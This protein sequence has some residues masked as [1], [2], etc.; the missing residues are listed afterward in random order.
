MSNKEIKEENLEGV[1]GGMV[2][3]QNIE[4]VGFYHAMGDGTEKA[5]AKLD[6]EEAR[7]Q[8][9]SKMMET[10]GRKRKR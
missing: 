9:S 4:G 5:L 7:C 10:P 2:S 1:S 8:L 6:P 3:R